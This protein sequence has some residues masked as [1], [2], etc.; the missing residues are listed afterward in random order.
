MRNQSRYFLLLLLVS[1]WLF[2]SCVK[3]LEGAGEGQERSYQT[4]HFRATATE[5]SGT[6]ATLDE[7]G[8]YVFERSDRLFVIDKAHVDDPSHAVLYGFLHL[9]A[10]EGDT[11]GLF[12]GDLMYF[13][14]SEPHEP[15]TPADNLEIVAT[16]VSGAD[17]LH[18]YTLHNGQITNASDAGYPNYPTNQVAVADEHGT[19]FQNAVRKYSHFTGTATYGNPSFTL[20]Q[21]S[22][23]LVFSI[24]FDDDSSSDQFMPDNASLTVTLTN[25]SS[26]RTGAVTASSGGGSF[27][28]ANFAMA[29]P[30][31]EQLSA[32]TKLDITD[33]NQR[34]PQ[35]TLNNG[36]ALTLKANNYYT[37]NRT[38]TD[39]EF[40]IRPDA[41]T[42]ITFHYTYDSHKV[43]YKLG[44]AGWENVTSSA[45]EVPAGQTMRVR[46]VELSH[47]D[48]RGILFESNNG[49][50]KCYLYGDIMSL[51][52]TNDA[53]TT[54]NTTVG[55]SAFLA[56][57]GVASPGTGTITH[58]DIPEGRPLFL[59]ATTTGD[60]C[61]KEMF[62]NCTSLTH[63]PQFSDPNDAERSAAAI[64]GSACQGMFE[65]CTGLMD[66]PALPAT[67]VGN[68]GYQG[69]FKG[70][71]SLRTTPALNASDLGDSAYY[72]MFE[73]C[74]EIVS[75]PELPAE[76][77]TANCY[78]S[79]FKNCIKLTTGPSALPATALYTSCYEAMFSGCIKLANAPAFPTTGMASAEKCYYQMFFDCQM[80]NTVPTGW[81]LP[82]TD[83]KTS[84]C[85]EMFEGCYALTTV[86]ALSSFSGT[87]IS[88]SGCQEMFSGCREISNASGISLASATSVGAS[89]C[90]AMFLDC[91]KLTTGPSA[92]PATTLSASCYEAMFSGCIRLTAPPAFPNTG[93]S[94]AEKCYYQM[95]LNC[96]AMNTV[97]GWG[98]PITD[99]QTSSCQEM[100]KGCTALTTAP[101]LSSFSGT[102]I[103]ESGCQEMF[104][105]CKNMT[106]ASAL[107]LASVTSVG[108][109]GCEAMFLDC[110]SL[111]TPPVL[112]T[113]AA[114]NTRSYKQ[115]F[116]SC[117]SLTAAPAMTVTSLT[118][119]ENCYEM[120]SGKLTINGFTPGLTDPCDNLED[121]SAIH[122]NAPTLTKACYYG[123]FMGCKVKSVPN[124]FLPAETLAV[125]CYMQMFLLCPKLESVPQN[126]LPGTTLQNGCYANM[127]RQCSKLK[128]PPD[129]KAINPAPGC[130]FGMF[131]GCTEA[132]RRLKCLIILTLSQQDK[133]RPGS[134]TDTAFPTPDVV[135][136]W[137]VINAWTVFNKW[138]HDAKN[139]NQG[140]GL[141]YNAAMPNGDAV[142]T[143]NDVGRVPTSWA[144][145]GVTE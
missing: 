116:R 31:G 106:N 101:A 12:D 75:A 81:A 122:L 8:H 76:N 14:S 68:S 34:Y 136:T 123:M 95:F 124:G 89:G 90:K 2:P 92:L 119:T 4:V 20:A 71:T 140:E 108:V 115:M 38:V 99:I 141:K 29:F 104:S 32:G 85:Q 144:R 82:I 65:G 88:A 78:N 79:M 77:I 128:D 16:L 72:G 64:A 43:Q 143:G 94:S 110:V 62:R 69:M 134:I 27:V 24:T 54:K 109:S 55:A 132:L 1:A 98:I 7:F 6:R 50:A 36:N 145:V 52:Y 44:E 125:A 26:T 120:F 83:I 118:G 17:E 47:S 40:C 74:T 11:V 66:A 111:S 80:M 133:T 46:A 21:H 35:Q 135:E 5:G 39:N 139:D 33:G 53:Y 56:L 96:K 10:G 131:R 23:F 107:S 45:I 70:C 127:F 41:A 9:V 138:L 3:Q 142:Y 117:K 126:L 37:I 137:S 51:V 58:I 59:P 28:Q 105:G 30:A 19:A 93:I 121:L 61:Y 86:P 130:Y 97:S 15:L 25:G 42:F 100:F 91:V 49:S 113:A 67:T 22:A 112:P 114:L 48:E 73:G 57:F 60:N 129:L 87:T 102:T 13:D 18:T 63:P 103:S 84:S